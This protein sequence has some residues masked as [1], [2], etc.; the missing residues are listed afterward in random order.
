[1]LRRD[2]YLPFKVELSEADRELVQYISTVNRSSTQ[3]NGWNF[4][5]KTFPRPKGKETRVIIT[6]YDLPR[7]DAMPHDAV[8]DDE[9]MVWYSEF[10]APYIG[11]LNPRT[12]E[13]KEWEVPVRKP[14]FPIGSLD[15]QLDPDGNPWLGMLFQGGTAKLDK[16]T[17]KVTAHPVPPEHDG[18]KTRTGMVAISPETGV[19]WFKASQ[20]RLVHGFDPKQG[21]VIASHKVPPVG[22]YGM[23]PDSRGNLVM[24]GMPGSVIGVMDP[25]S[26]EVS[27][28]PTPTPRAGPRRGQL[29]AQDRA[30][31]AEFYAQKI[32][33]FDPRTTEI[34]EWGLGTPYGGT[35]DAVPD[36]NGEVWSGGMHTD[37]IFRLNPATGEV[38]RYL[39][40]RL[41]VNIRR[42]DVDDST[43]PVAVWIGENH[44]AKLAKIEPLE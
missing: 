6:E 20:D 10:S 28:Y 2:V 36:N 44:H 7:P 12:G 9:G 41:G 27:T 26:G 5:L 19:V 34:K 15:I 32:G 30:W 22:F 40:P 11:R 4:E 25:A 29:D 43:S 18:V 17:G 1:L 39:L 35:Y 13:I 8:S 21:K 33:M 24:F 14:D 3:G 16:K 37:Y 23:E 38:T 31:F 42:M